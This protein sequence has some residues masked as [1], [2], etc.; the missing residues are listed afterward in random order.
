MANQITIK[1]RMIR[2]RRVSA[3]IKGTKNRPRLGVFRSNRLIYAF[4]ADDDAGKVIG[5]VSV[6][7]I[8]PDKQNP[9]TK[10]RQANETGKAIATLALAQK[11]KEVVFDRSGY[12]YAGRVKALAEGARQGGLIF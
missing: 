3:K 10:I 11:I 2:K 8:K 5:Q 12:R 9:F 7:D 6:T 1:G 4:L